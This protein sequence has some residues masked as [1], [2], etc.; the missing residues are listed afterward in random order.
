MS[1]KGP[2]HRRDHGS[3]FWWSAP[4][5]QRD[6]RPWRLALQFCV[7]AVGWLAAWIAFRSGA[8]GIALPLLFG[9]LIANDAILFWTH[10][11]ATRRTRLLTFWMAGLASIQFALAVEAWVFDAFDP[12]GFALAGIFVHIAIGMLARRSLAPPPSVDPDV[13]E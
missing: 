5:W 12:A 13:F 9:V 6:W 10:Q 3:L 4:A 8:A 1:G 7:L 11:S 2:R